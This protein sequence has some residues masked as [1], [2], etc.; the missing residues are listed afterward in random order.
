MSSSFIWILYKQWR[1]EGERS[2]WGTCAPGGTVQRAAFGGTKI[3]NAEIWPFMA[4][5]RSHYRQR[6]FMPHNSLPVLGPHSS[7]HCST[8]PHKA[9]CTL[10]NLHCWSD[11][12]FTSCKTVE[13]RYCPVT[14]LLAIAIQCFA[15]FTC[16][17]IIL[18][19]IWKFCMKFGHLI[20]RKI[21]KFVASLLNHILH[22]V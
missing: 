11:W 12:S 8:T 17:Q 1:R 16:F 14:V 13:D 18:H 15:L 9:M 3:W 19:K 21:F 4:N 7:C 20:P 5:W 2:A 6:Y 22:C 10:R